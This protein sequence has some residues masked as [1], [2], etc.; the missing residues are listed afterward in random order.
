MVKQNGASTMCGCLVQEENMNIDGPN[1]QSQRSVSQV[2]LTKHI[3]GDHCKADGIYTM[4]HADV[5]LGL[6]LC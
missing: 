2:T 1:N 6:V 5:P 4:P 3:I